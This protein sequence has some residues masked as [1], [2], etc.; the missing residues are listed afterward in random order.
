M[1]GI[2]VDTLIGLLQIKKRHSYLLLNFDQT[3]HHA[4]VLGNISVSFGTFTNY[5]VNSGI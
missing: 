4:L 5:L 1:T 3:S 2:S